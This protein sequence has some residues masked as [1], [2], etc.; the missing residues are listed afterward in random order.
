MCVTGTITAAAARWKTPCGGTKVNG[1][2]CWRRRE[3]L[4]RLCVCPSVWLCTCIPHMCN[5]H[6]C[7]FK[8]G[9]ACRSLKDVSMNNQLECY[10]HFEMRVI[11]T[12]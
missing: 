6:A 9:G 4:P 10:L 7:V 2:I 3:V 5:L 1:S 12:R 11:K 8:H